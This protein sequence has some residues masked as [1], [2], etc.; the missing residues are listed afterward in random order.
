MINI[1]NIDDNKCFKWFLI[2]HLHPVDY[3][4]AIVRHVDKD[5]ARELDFKD[6]RILVKI[7]DIHKIK[8]KEMYRISVFGYE[9]KDKYPIYVSINIFQRHVDLSLIGEEYER[10]YVLIKDFN[11]FMY[12]H[13]LSRGRKHFVVIVYKRLVQQKN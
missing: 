5:F 12:N 7:R 6:E 1:Q 13:T 2:R 9:N 10:H 8:K 3:H 11:T 4:P